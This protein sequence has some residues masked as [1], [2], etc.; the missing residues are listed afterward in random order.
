VH[1]RDP[2]AHDCAA[3]YSPNPV[4]FLPAHYKQRRSRGKNSSY[5]RQ[6]HGGPVIENRH[7]QTKSQHSY[8]VH[9]PNAQAHGRRPASK[10]DKANSAGGRSDTARQVKSGVRRTNRDQD[11]ERNQTVIVRRDHRLTAFDAVRDCFR[12]CSP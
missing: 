10:P 1:G 7:W 8:V 6:Q 3:D 4:H 5:K 12:I 11:R 9:G 2:A